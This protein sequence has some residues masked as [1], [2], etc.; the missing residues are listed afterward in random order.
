VLAILSL[1][2]IFSC[3]LFAGAAVWIQTRDPVWLGGA[4]AMLAVIPVTLIVIFPTNQKLAPGRDLASSET[5]ALLET[6]G[7][8][9]GIQS[10]LSLFAAVL[11]IWAA[12]R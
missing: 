1:V 6:W 2:A 10:L 12:V 8:L 3:T 9:H 5:R 11:Y 7:R 4:V